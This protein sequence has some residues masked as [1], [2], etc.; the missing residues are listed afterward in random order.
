MFRPAYERYQQASTISDLAAI[1]RKVED[2]AVKMVERANILKGNA[3]SLYE[4]SGCRFALETYKL[5]YELNPEDPLILA[6]IQ[7]CDPNFNPNG[8]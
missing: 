4:Y 6:G 8:E 3:R 5:A 2:L 1:N 7:K